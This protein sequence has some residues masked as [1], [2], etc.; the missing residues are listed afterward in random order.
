[1]EEL[2][3][4]FPAS[5][6]LQSGRDWASGRGVGAAFPAHLPCPSLALAAVRARHDRPAGAAG[7][8]PQAMARHHAQPWLPLQH[9]GR[10][11]SLGKGDSRE[12]AGLRASRSRS[13]S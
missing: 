5:F 7:M 2:Q 3:K 1:M 10:V 11:R 8:A 9:T 6:A 13:R 12:M 4:H